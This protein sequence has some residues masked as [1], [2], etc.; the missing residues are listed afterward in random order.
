M[1]ATK[2]KFNALLQGIGA[3]PTS[4]AASPS[5]DNIHAT[6]ASL[7]APASPYPASSP[8]AS[9][10]SPLISRTPSAA[11]N[12][13]NDPA[14]MRLFSN[15]PSAS[16]AT[17]DYLKRRRVGTPSSTPAGDRAD[18][19]SIS[20]VGGGAGVTLRRT[21][22]S[23][24]SSTSLVA[25]RDKAG[26]SAPRYCPGDRDELVRRLATFQEITDW[27]P[28]P[29]RVNEIE[30]AKRGWVC[31]GK[32]RLRCTLCSKEL[33]VK[34]NRKVVDGKEVSVLVASEIEDALVDKYVELMVEA[35]QDDC[36]WRKRG[37][38]DHLIRLPL[39]NSHS[40]LEG[41]RKRYDE[42]CFRKDFLPYE[43]NLRLPESL[44]LNAILRDLPPSFFTEP[45]RPAPPRG[46]PDGPALTAAPNRSAL[47]L[48]LMGWQGLENP[49]IG[50]VPNSA[51]CHT[52]LRRLG[53]WMFKSKEVDPDTNAVLVPAAMD[54][55]DPLREHRF[56]CPWNNAEVQRNPGGGGGGG[57][58]TNS[59][60]RLA[61]W[62]V[63]AQVVKNEAY[64]RNRGAKGG[65]SGGGVGSRLFGHKGSKSVGGQPVPAATAPTTPVRSST[66]A[67]AA[68]A[69]ATTPPRAGADEEPE[70]D[71][72]TR[73]AK[74]KERWARLRRVK[75]L[76]DPKGSKK[77]QRM[78]TTASRPG[79]GHST[80]RPETGG[81]A[82]VQAG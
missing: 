23:L 12:D 21:I 9:R 64:L 6:P 25:G 8:L 53:L 41:L 69:G 61:G 67:T 72:A 22:G 13:T 82:S 77:A 14:T 65:N 35:H 78:T 57:S 28:K 17:A 15:S 18:S 71:E 3:R 47:A 45:P 50:A 27:T 30:W 19:P 7:A 80:P 33:V 26:S 81:G 32:E 48:A 63:L 75:S 52:C 70:E 60:S 62:Q 11:N 54:H 24:S 1:H 68:A 40:A 58:S 20:V 2:R 43:F 56:F 76:F 79:T 49:K 4:P 37:S 5:S 55:L 51:S 31:Q 39:A 16:A 29:D 38:D 46:L 34:L 42:L 10:S 66:T 44:D 73:D 59:S 36:L 74:D